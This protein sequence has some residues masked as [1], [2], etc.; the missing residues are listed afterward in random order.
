VGIPDAPAARF[1]FD[2]NDLGLSLNF[3]EKGAIPPQSD[4]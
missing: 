3:E 1:L 2:S 4:L